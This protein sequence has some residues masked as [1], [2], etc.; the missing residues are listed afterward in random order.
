MHSR[1][2]MN[3]GFHKEYEI[4]IYFSVVKKKT[5]HRKLSAPRIHIKRSS[6]NTQENKPKLAKYIAHLVPL[7]LP[8]DYLLY[9]FDRWW[10]D[11]AETLSL[12]ERVISLLVAMFVERYFIRVKHEAQFKGI[13]YR[14]I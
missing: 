14:L 7:H 10:V 3:L 8:I 11:K 2:R 6:R 4:A 12:M 1:P 9:S 5:E 13:N